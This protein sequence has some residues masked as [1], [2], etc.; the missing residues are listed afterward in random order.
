M[1]VIQQHFCEEL[2]NIDMLFKDEIQNCEFILTI[3][4][5]EVEKAKKLGKVN[6]YVELLKL[7]DEN[8]INII[9]RFVNFKYDTEEI[10]EE[11]LLRP[12]FIFSRSTLN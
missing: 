10:P 9:I 12:L 4:K 11:W 8:V 5:E 2:E 6:V 3:L 7:I 1:E